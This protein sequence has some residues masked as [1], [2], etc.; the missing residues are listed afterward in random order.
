MAALLMLGAMVLGAA[1]AVFYSA[2][3]QIYYGT[4][5][6]VEVCTSSRLLCGHPEYLAYAA[7]ASLTLGLGFLIGRALGGE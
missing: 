4:G 5:W 6:A 2:Q 1:G 7:A 3:K